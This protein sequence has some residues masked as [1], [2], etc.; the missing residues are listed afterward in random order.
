MAKLFG[1]NCEFKSFSFNEF[2]KSSELINDLINRIDAHK[3]SKTE[4]RKRRKKSPIL[5]IRRRLSS[6]PTPLNVPSLKLF[7]IKNDKSINFKGTY[8]IFHKK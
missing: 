7:S 4:K 1:P 3:K 6:T 5:G 8:Y 2:R